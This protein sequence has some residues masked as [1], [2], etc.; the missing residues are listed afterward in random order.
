MEFGLSLRYM[1]M[2]KQSKVGIRV[3]R[4]ETLQSKAATESP[5]EVD[6]IYRI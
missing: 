5:D 4:L 6:C 2:N 3:K 1:S